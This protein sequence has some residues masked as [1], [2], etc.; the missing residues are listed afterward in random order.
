MKMNLPYP[1]RYALNALRRAGYQAYCVGGCVRDMLNGDTPHDFDW[2]R[3]ILPTH[4]GTP[5]LTRK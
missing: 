4:C 5:T 3:L 1:V 2:T